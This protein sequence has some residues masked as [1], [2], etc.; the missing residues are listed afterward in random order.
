MWCTKQNFTV[1]IYVFQ[2]LKNQEQN[3]NCK[4]KWL[5]FLHIEQQWVGF[6]Y[7]S[8]EAFI[9]SQQYKVFGLT[10]WNCRYTLY[11]FVHLIV[12]TIIIKY[13]QFFFF[14]PNLFMPQFPFCHSINI[15]HPDENT[16]TE[17]CVDMLNILWYL[18][19]YCRFWFL[20]FYSAYH[21]FA[22]D[23]TNSRF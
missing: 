3:I 19:V 13:T 9:I 6:L 12:K 1:L 20:E 21:F 18:P 7:R 10:Q 4:L 5:L 23:V 16:A 22:Q 8:Y 17:I 15:S 14:H 2:F 11:I